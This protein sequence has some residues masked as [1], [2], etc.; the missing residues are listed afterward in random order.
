MSQCDDQILTLNYSNT[1]YFCSFLKCVYLKTLSVRDH[2]FGDMNRWLWDNVVKIL[3]RKLKTLS[4]REITALVTLTD[5]YG[6][7]L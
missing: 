2:S 5:G 1:I 4:V 7:T 6:T 3:P